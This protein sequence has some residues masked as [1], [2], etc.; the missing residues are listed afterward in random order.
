MELVLEKLSIIKTIYRLSKI[1][2]KN[3][4]RLMAIAFEHR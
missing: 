3:L 1:G 4:L 2:E